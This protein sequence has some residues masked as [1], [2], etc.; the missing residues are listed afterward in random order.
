MIVQANLGHRL[1]VL[2]PSV[3]SDPSVRTMIVSR[4]VRDTV[5]AAFPDNWDGLRLADFRQ[6]LDAFTTNEE[7]TV[8]ENPYKKPNDCFMA[9]VDPVMLEVFDVRTLYGPGI[10]TFGCFLDKDCFAALTWN[11]R[12]EMNFDREC[13]RCHHDWQQI[14]GSLAPFSKGRQL[15]E[16]LTNFL[17]L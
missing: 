2:E 10:R 17:A 14:F 16:Y 8:S 7:I 11:Y 3:K 6:T 1:F 12:E 15:H 4:E 13:K 5:D 9:R